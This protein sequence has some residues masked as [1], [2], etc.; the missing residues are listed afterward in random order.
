MSQ[1]LVIVD[2]VAIFRLTGVPYT[3]RP[4]PQVR[5]PLSRKI[6]IVIKKVCDEGAVSPQIINLPPMTLEHN[7]L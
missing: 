1:K 3:P 7:P 2:K 5:T 6:L 4:H